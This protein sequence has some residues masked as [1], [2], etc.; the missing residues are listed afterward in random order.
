MQNDAGQKGLHSHQRF[1][2]ISMCTTMS[3]SV[4]TPF[5]PESP[6]FMFNDTVTGAGESGSV[7]LYLIKN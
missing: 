6:F 2:Q 4:C 5:V 1:S 3:P 7:R